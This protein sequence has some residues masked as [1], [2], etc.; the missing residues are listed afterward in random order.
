MIDRPP[1]VKR[2][3]I[4][5]GAGFIG[6]NLAAHYLSQGIKVVVFDN[7]SRRGADANAAWLAD[8]DN[9]GL[10]IVVGDVR[11]FDSLREAMHGCD[12]AVHLAAQVAVTTSVEDPREDFQINAVGGFNLLEAARGSGSDPIVVYASTNKVYGSLSGLEIAEHPKR[13][14]FHD[15]PLGVP[16]TF[17]IDLHSPYGCSKGA[18]DLYMLDYARIY[19]LRTVVMRQSCIYGPRQ[20][21]I[22]DQGWVA[23]FVISSVLGR[24]ITIY[25]DGRQVRDV[26]HVHDLIAAFDRAVER[27]EVSRGQAYNLGGGPR[28]ATSLLEMVERM[29]R[30]LGLPV[31]LHYQNWRPGDQKVYISDVRKAE[32]ELGWV[33]HTDFGAGLRQLR[34]WVVANQALFEAAQPQTDHPDTVPQNG[35]PTVRAQA[36]DPPQAVPLPR[37]SDAESAA[38]RVQEITGS[39]KEVP[40]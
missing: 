16:E 32:A 11:N 33:P 37:L 19:G 15:R 28:N 18:T 21:G 34:D 27:I 30:E 22:E 8:L 24:P 9:P 40:R 31:E 35:V 20:F 7:F 13:Y 38:R 39:M 6:S 14:A 25:G 3:L 5:G 10:S 4:T 29:R 17:P 1:A 36:P 23:H 26:L 12:L 2:A